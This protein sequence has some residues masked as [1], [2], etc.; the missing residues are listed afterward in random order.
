MDDLA[1]A[2]VRSGRE[3]TPDVT[4]R[5]RAGVRVPSVNPAAAP[6]EQAV[7]EGAFQ[8]YFAAELEGAGCRVRMWEPDAD[9]LRA[10][11]PELQHVIPAEGFRDRPNVVG[12][13]PPGDREDG[14]RAHLVLNSHADTVGVG[15]PS[16][17][18]A[19]PFGG[20]LIG[21]KILGVGAADAKGCLF[22]FLGAL[23]ALRAA[24]VRLRR[25]VMIQSVV[26]EESG[27][28]GTLECLREGY[29]GTAAVVGEPT[30]LCACLG[31]RGSV[32]LEIEITGRK[33]HPGEGWRG[34]NAIEL[35]WR[36][37]AAL[38][39]LRGELDRTQMHPLWASLP[40][41][42]VWN[43][44]AL[45]SGP[46]SRAVPDRCG[47][48]YSVGLIGTEAGAEMEARV[49]AAL[50]TVTAGDPWLASHPPVIRW[51]TRDRWPTVT[52]PGHPAAVAMTAV[53]AALGEDGAT[54]RGFS[55][56]AD[57]R[58]LVRLGG[59]PT[60][61]FGPGDIHRCHGPEE[62]LPV[63]ELRRAITWTALFLAGYCGT[64]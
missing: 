53:G 58:Y 30:S 51:T 60:L 54:P 11:Y 20:D 50:R 19:P 9:A 25:S 42:H 14:R 22:T 64:A 62:E 56:V 43:L 23:L 57:T 40:Q 29:T 7:G 37:V 15:D 17:W 1:E 47:F 33:A 5:L 48:H 55:A 49:D 18:P 4:D 13:F 31:T 12:W 44:M 16:S 28:A 59:I 8:R 36:Y 39:R 2:I 35:A 63:D 52:D 27:G 6:G 45:N 24:G 21:D 61:T 38:E 3:V 41:G 32:D 34:V 26:G 10:R 46:T